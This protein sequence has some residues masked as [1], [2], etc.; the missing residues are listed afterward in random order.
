MLGLIWAEARDGIIGRDGVMPWHLPEDLAHFKAVTLGHPVVMGRRTWDSIEPRF[1]P[2][3]GRRNLVITRD[4]GF[5]AEGAE[6]A[7]SL[8][9]ALALADESDDD[10]WVI[11]GGSVYAATIDRADRLE[12][13][14]LDVE[15]DG[16]T[17]APRIGADWRTPGDPD[18]QTSR[19]GLRYRFRTYER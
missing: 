6:V 19:T 10:V 12:V 8:D 18:W 9:A 15:V 11:G 13:T 1:R 16:D 5:S 7:H 3:V 14:E 2:L 17:R 4:P